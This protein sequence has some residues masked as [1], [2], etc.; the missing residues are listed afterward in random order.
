V[1]CGHWGRGGCL[2]VGEGECTLGWDGMMIGFSVGGF[3]T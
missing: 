3:P 2:G 1:G